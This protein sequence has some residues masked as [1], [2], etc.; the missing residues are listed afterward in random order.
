MTHTDITRYKEIVNRYSEKNSVAQGRPKRFDRELRFFAR[1]EQYDA[2][3][4]EADRERRDRSDM[5]RL[6]I[7]EALQ[8]RTQEAEMKRAGESPT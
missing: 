8:A 6:L 7:D 2:V 5:L 1:Q 4:S 3:Q